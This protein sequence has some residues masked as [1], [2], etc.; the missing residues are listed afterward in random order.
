[1]ND[2]YALSRRT[3]LRLTSGSLASLGLMNS[4]AQSAPSYKALVCVFLFGGNDGHNT[5]VPLNQQQYNNYKAIRGNL[6]LP[7]T[8]AK[9][10]SVST[11]NGTPYGINDGLQSI[12]PLW[13]QGKLAVVT[14]VGMLI[15]PTTRA[16]VL[17]GTAQLPTN[18]YSH[19]DQVAQMQSGAPNT[20]TGTGWAGRVADSLYTPGGPSFP[21]SISMSGP[22][23]F[24]TGNAVQSASLIPGFDMTQYGFD[25][26][27]ATAASARKVAMQE[28]LTF[29]NGLALVQSANKVSTDALNLNNMLKSLSSG[30]PLT[31]TFPT[32]NIG[33]QLKEVAKIIKLR[34]TIGLN[35]QVFFCSLGGFDTHGGQSWQQWDLFHQ[36]GDAMAAFYNAT[37]ELGVADQVTTFTESEF[38][39]SLEPSGSGSDHGWGSHHF[40]MGGAVKGGNLYGTFPTLALGSPDDATGRGVLIPTTSLDQYGATM[41]KWF[42]VPD[43]AMPGI[44]PSLQN[45]TVKDLGFLT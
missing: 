36:L 1:M 8:D 5:I 39:R 30:S 27:P 10:L 43:A 6:S 45:F 20:S 3:F 19:S 18:L 32:T 22:A 16:E 35:R 38:G 40:V 4:Y 14:N 25:N 21:S 37:V 34:S 42:G 41:A 29:D 24:C 7:G 44:F 9:L 12:H 13:A 2:K 15:R 26:W 17:A 11:P 33:A 31:T 28:L 23:L